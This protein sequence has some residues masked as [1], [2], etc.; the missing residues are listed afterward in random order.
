M[1]YSPQEFY[2]DPMLIKT[3][4]HPDD[5][6]AI[7]EVSVHNRRYGISRWLHKTGHYVLLEQHSWPVYHDNDCI[8]VE[9]ISR[10]ITNRMQSLPLV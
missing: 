10:D 7:G 4:I 8:G 6:K 3:L 1:G 5:K 9:A 2:D